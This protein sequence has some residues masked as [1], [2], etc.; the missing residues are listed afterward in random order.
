MRANITSLE[1][2]QNIMIEKGLAI[3]AIPLSSRVV[4]ELS[5]QSEYPNGCAQYLE[6]FKREMWVEEKKNKHGG[7]FVVES[8]CGTGATVKFAARNFYHSLEELIDDIKG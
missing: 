1:A 4:V 3:R 2:L 5:H 7:Q 8:Y 6:K